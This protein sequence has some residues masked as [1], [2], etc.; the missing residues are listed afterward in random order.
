MHMIIYVN[1]NV[2]LYI[3]TKYA[4]DY[5]YNVPKNYVYIFF[6]I[7]NDLFGS[8]MGSNIPFPILI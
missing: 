1:K 4:Y 5:I 7:P 8:T 2:I 3:Y 6:P